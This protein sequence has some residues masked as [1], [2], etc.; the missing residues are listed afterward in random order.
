MTPPALRVQGSSP[1]AARLAPLVEAAQRC[2]QRNIV[3]GRGPHEPERYLRAGGGY[4][5]PWTRDAAINAWQAGAWLWPQISRTTL[6]MVLEPDGS[7]VVWDTQWWDQIVW[8]IGGYELAVTSGDTEW[9]AHTYR[10]GAA[11]LA[12]LDE[13]C[14]DQSSCLYR[15]PAVMADGITGYPPELHDPARA[16]DSF[17][18]DHAATHRI[19]CLSTNA[20]YV[21]ALRRLADLAGWLGD[22]PAPWRAR[23]DALAQRVRERFTRSDGRL[24]YLARVGDGS[25]LAPPPSPARDRN[26][27]QYPPHQEGLGWALVVLADVVP[28]DHARALVAAVEHAPHGLPAV[29]PPFD[30]FDDHR[31]GRH[32]AALWPMIGGVWAQAVASTGDTAAFGTELDLL[33]A[34][35]EGCGNEFFELYHPTTGVPDGGWQAGRRWRSEPDQTWS[36]TT[37]LGCVLHGLAG[38]RP[39]AVGLGFA[40]SLPAGADGLDLVGLPWRDT[41]LTIRLRGTGSTIERFV[42]DGE[43]RDPDLPWV[44]AAHPPATVEIHCTEGSLR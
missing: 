6:D 33:C 29:W 36:A 4:P 24:A 18:L 12:R 20:L 26:R 25:Y 42:V 27:P 43:R 22:D 21:W 1:W 39:D 44:S 32:G 5:D 15:G 38:L 9:A 30:G 14:F 31:F 28:A 34:L 2:V 7:R 40:P 19:A 17:V 11:T 8:V 16:G 10:V 3:P 41:T 13:R 35:F 23:A 37:L